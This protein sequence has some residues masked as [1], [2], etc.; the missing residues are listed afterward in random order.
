MYEGAPTSV[1]SY[2]SVIS[3]GSA[4]FVLMMILVKVFAPIVE[5]WQMMLYG[6]IVLTISIANLFAIRQQNLKRFMAFS[7]ISQAGYLMLGVI[8][9]CV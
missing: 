2:L 9:R 6:L 8:A 7:S 1:T 5:Q 4:V 3:K